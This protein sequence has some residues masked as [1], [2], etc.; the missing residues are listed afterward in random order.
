[1]AGEPIKGPAFCLSS[2]EKQYGRSIA[3]R[4][5]AQV[6]MPSGADMERCIGRQ[7]ARFGQLRFD[8]LDD[9]VAEGLARRQPI[10]AEEPGEETLELVA[11]PPGRQGSE[12]VQFG[13]EG[14]GLMQIM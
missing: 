12:I 6:S 5:L 9:H 8:G 3:E 4:S 2:I 11:T 13:S 14:F 10:F 7:A 1:M